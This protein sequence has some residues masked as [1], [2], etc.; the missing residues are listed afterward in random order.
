MNKK[1][2]II[3]FLDIFHKSLAGEEKHHRIYTLNPKTYEFRD[4]IMI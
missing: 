4:I 3:E 2:Q 1:G